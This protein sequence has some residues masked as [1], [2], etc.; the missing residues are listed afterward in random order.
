MA[1]AQIIEK[2]TQE[3]ETIIRFNNGSDNLIA[4][5]ASVDDAITLINR[6]KKIY[7]VTWEGLHEV[8]LID[9]SGTGW[10]QTF[11]GHGYILG[12]DSRLYF[13]GEER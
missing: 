8:K 12:T 2:W 6:S 10:I 11:S 4:V 3:T 1:N 5:K 9:K 13:S 7:L